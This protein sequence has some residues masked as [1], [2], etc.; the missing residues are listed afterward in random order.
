MNDLV[1]DTSR[2][3]RAAL[4]RIIKRAAELQTVERD[5]GEG[6][7]EQ[8]LLQLGQDVGIPGRYLQ[9]ALLEEQS[10]AVILAEPGLAAW[11]AGPRYVVAQRS[12]PGSV[13][14]VRAALNHWMTE[15][16]L[17]TVRRRFPDRTSWEPRRDMMAS[18]KRGLEVGGRP[19]RLARAREIIG[20]VS[21]LDDTTCLVQLLAD[22]SNT[23]RG[24]LGGAATLAG[25]GAVATTI[26]ITLGVMLPIA[27]LPA[28]IGLVAGAAL[29][30]R[31]I[32]HVEQ[33][34]VSL[35]QVLDRLEHGEVRPDGSGGRGLGTFERLAREIR[36]SLG[37]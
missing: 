29:A 24:H 8:E 22:L 4:E 35:E 5:I 12:V 17:L 9:Q 7:T 28:G 6:L 20:Q 13:D 21:R 37:T 26:G 18:L 2:I 1:P 3:D 31:R 11:L 25:S 10:R 30:R 34:Q 33:L 23:R 19:Y 32:G 15:G 27:L 16:E 14:G 36:R